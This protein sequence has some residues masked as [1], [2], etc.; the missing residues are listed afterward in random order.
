[1]L[2]YDVLPSF[3]TVRGKLCWAGLFGVLAVSFAASVVYG[4]TYTLLKEDRG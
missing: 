1:M 4:V 3:Q 2:G